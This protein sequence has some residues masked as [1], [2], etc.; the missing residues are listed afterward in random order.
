MYLNNNELLGESIELKT[1]AS[2]VSEE[3]VAE[4]ITDVIATA[5]C[6]GRSLD[7]LLTEVLAEDPQLDQSQRLWLSQIV[8]QAWQLL[9][10]Q[11][12]E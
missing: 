3:I 6:Q 2:K 1:S 8:R 5:R 7:D 4:A 9:P 12:Q 10:D 11:H